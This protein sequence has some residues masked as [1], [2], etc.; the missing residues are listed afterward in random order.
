MTM[1]KLAIALVAISTF[2]G[3]GFAQGTK[4]GVVD[5][6]VVIQKSA[7]GKKFFDEYQV[8][9][10]SKKDSIDAQ[11]EAY[12][13]AEKD[14]NAKSGSLSED[15]RLESYQALERQQTDIR[16]MQEDAKRES[17][18]KLSVG[19]DKFRKELAPLIRQVAQEMGLDLVLNYGPNSNMVYFSDTINITDAVIAKYDA[20]GN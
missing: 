19:L 12:R 11:I 9:A 20:Q 3:F 13:A 6:D 4:I 1:K 10:K 2:A 5:A 17:E 15:K 18:A 8:F 14:Y 7:K 16:R